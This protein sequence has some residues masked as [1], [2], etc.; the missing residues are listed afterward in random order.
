MD[1][2]KETKRISQLR[3]EKNNLEAQVEV[4]SS[5]L[6]RVR[7][8]NAMLKS[9]NER[10]EDEIT[11]LHCDLIYSKLVKNKTPQYEN[12]SHSKKKQIYG[13]FAICSISALMAG[14]SLALESKETVDYAIMLLV[15]LSSIA[16]LFDTGKYFYACTNRRLSWDIYKGLS[17]G[18]CL[19]ALGLSIMTDEGYITL[20]KPISIYFSIIVWKNVLENYLNKN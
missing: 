14:I 15:V 11:S 8:K 7:E 5:E 2:S 20:S 6:S 18:M 10:L 9:D 19:I 13:F 17:A 16:E 12:L 4:L 1:T 3:E